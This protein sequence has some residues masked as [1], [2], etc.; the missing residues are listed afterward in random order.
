MK[1][2]ETGQI[3]VRLHVSSHASSL[4]S[5]MTGDRWPPQ[6]SRVLFAGSLAITRL[7]PDSATQEHTLESVAGSPAIAR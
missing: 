7:T 5:A 3:E 6:G 4:A 2:S 1:T